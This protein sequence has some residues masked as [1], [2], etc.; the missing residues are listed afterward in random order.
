MA[1]RYQKSSPF[2]REL[3][4]LLVDH[5]ALFGRHKAIWRI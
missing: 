4:E 1:V 2:F 5:F 3:D